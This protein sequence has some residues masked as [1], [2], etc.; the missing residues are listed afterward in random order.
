MSRSRNLTICSVLAILLCFDF[1][2]ARHNL[3]VIGGHGGHG[4]H[5]GGHKKTIFGKLFN[6][7]NRFLVQPSL[8]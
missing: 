7:L 3:I 6:L 8:L 5:S 2:F 1:V 4:H